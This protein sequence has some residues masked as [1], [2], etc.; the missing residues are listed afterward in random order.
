MLASSNNLQQFIEWFGIIYFSMFSF[1]CLDCFYYKIGKSIVFKS[2]CG[3]RYNK[4]GSFGETFG[5]E[6]HEMFTLCKP[7][8]VAP[9]PRTKSRSSWQESKWGQGQDKDHIYVSPPVDKGSGRKIA[10]S[11]VP[12]LTCKIQILK[13]GWGEGIQQNPWWE[14]FIM[15]LRKLKVQ[16]PSYH[17]PFQTKGGL[18][19]SLCVLNW[20]PQLKM[21]KRKHLI[22]ATSSVT[23]SP[24]TSPISTVVTLGELSRPWHFGDWGLYTYWTVTFLCIVSH[25]GASP[26]SVH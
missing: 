15:R 13:A 23:S 19:S 2:Y 5:K 26:A 16:G 24:N 14:R 11:Y 22:T 6:K 17:Q 18:Y 12:H 7:R 4:D 1:I 3:F 20:S 21:Y 9:Q 25:L 10:K 8:K